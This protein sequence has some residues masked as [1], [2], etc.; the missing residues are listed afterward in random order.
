MAHSPNP[1]LLAELLNWCDNA[2]VH[3]ANALI[4]SDVPT[5]AV[6]GDIT[7][8]LEPVKVLKFLIN[9]KD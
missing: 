9:L 8:S 2:K 6:V 4:L 3:P 7:E 5:E 1:Q